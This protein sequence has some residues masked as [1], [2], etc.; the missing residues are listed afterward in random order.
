MT[1]IFVIDD[2]PVYIDGIKSAF[3]DGEDKIKVS[4]WA[5]SVKEAI[6]KLKRSRAKIVLLDLLMPV[7]NGV[8]F[9]LTLKNN[10][11]EKKVIALTGAL[12]P[13]ILYN[14]WINKADAILMKYSKKQDIVDTIHS[15]LDGNRILGDDV[16]E[17]Y[18]LL[19]NGDIKPT[20]LTVS[21]QQVI[22]LLAKGHTRKKTASILGSTPNAVHF[23]CR[24][25]FK[26]L[27]TNNITG[28]VKEA[29]RQG[30]VT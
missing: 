27:K 15:V 2:H 23:H 6:P 16:P 4:G 7:V 30:L 28:A 3:K 13:T 10:F 25:L 17:F 18:E 19:F 9:C 21:E 22:N 5:T 26:K 29:R 20:K 8:D 1:N 14:T 11:P 24:N 12:N